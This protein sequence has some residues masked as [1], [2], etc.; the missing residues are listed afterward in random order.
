[1][2][3][4]K[5]IGIGIVGAGWVADNIHAPCHMKNPSAKIVAVADILEKAAKSLAQKYGCK[6]WYTDYK[7][8]FERSD[9]DVIDICVPN[10]RHA[11]ISVSATEAGKNV[12]CEKPLAISVEQADKMVAS[13]KRHGVKLMYAENSLFAPALTRAKGIID[14]GGIG[15][16]LYI[17]ARETHSG[18][19]SPFA[20]QKKY[21]GG[22]CLLHLGCHPVGESLWLIDKPVKRVYAE[23]GNLYHDIEVEDFATLL[24]RFEDDRASTVQAN[25]ITKGGMDDRVE[26]Y[27]T[28]GVMLVNWTKSDQVRVFSE[29]GYSYAVEKVDITTGWANVTVNDLW[30]LGYTN[31]LRH[32]V[33]C[34]AEDKKPF[35]NGEFGR[36]V[37]KVIF[38]GYKSAEEGKPITLQTSPCTH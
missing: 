16:I 34:V 38:A 4:L 29:K 6:A 25:Y 10:Y 24:M 12:I 19:H 2:I 37:L 17:E 21:S 32:F 30:D 15:K 11:D 36:N 1:V 13:A 26:I 3:K 9:I 28:D 31:E 8:M 35:P 22:G 20:I 27:G 7:K 14:E 5:K 18:S 33:E 23:T